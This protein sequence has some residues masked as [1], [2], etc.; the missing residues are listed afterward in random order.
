MIS[1]P[2]RYQDLAGRLCSGKNKKILN[3]PVDPAGAFVFSVV[4]SSCCW[5]I[6]HCPTLSGVPR[7][8]A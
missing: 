2:L 1:A 8:E 5:G 4:R 3:A 6:F 7:R